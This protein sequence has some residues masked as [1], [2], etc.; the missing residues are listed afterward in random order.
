MLKS[1]VNIIRFS[2]FY[3]KLYID[4][5]KVLKYTKQL[6]QEVKPKF[7]NWDA[8]IDAENQRRMRGYILIQTLWTAGFCLLRGERI[9]SNELK[10]IVNISA[11]APLYD[12]F[13]D[14][15]EMPS[16]KIHALVNTPFDYKP[17]SDIE[18]LFLEFSK[19]IHENVHNV[20]F[21][22]E[23]AKNVFKAQYES[24]KLVSENLL[25]RDF[26][27][28]IAFNKGGETV[29]CMCNMLNKKLSNEEHK[30]MAQLGG[31]A[32]YLDDIFDLREDYMEGRQTLANPIENTIAL[33]KSFLDEIKK[34]KKGL[35]ISSF[36]KANQIA[37]YI[38][39][40]YILGA[41]LLCTERY[42]LLEEKTNGVFKIDQYSRDEMVLDM[43]RWSNRIKAFKLSLTL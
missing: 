28:E 39:V 42:E 27:K 20:P 40:S 43:D 9:K 41:T 38:P 16:Q 1:V 11:L 4:Y 25:D 17:D 31:I 34:F 35:E 37:F 29:I 7:Q 18:M 5:R 26:V 19:R 10:A 23:N 36:K 21:Y 2:P 15:V 3:V 6:F 30:L 32:Q 24:K 33:R 14:K 13:F 8:L 12:D 22:L